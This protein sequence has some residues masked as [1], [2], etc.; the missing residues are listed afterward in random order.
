MGVWHGLL[1]RRSAWYSD[2][3][4][5]WANLAEEPLGF[6]GIGFSPMFMLLKPTFSLRSSTPAAAG[7]SL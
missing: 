3:S 4:S 7:A 1:Q 6:R 2:I 5:R